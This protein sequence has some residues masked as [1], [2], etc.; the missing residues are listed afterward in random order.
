MKLNIVIESMNFD[1]NE[2][3]KTQLD[4]NPCNLCLLGKG[5]MCADRKF[6]RWDSHREIYIKKDVTEIKE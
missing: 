5:I 4:K 2:M 1:N 3:M 6:C